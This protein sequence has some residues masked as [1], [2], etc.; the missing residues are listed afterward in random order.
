MQA[1]FTASA[2]NPD[3]SFLTAVA[4]QIVSKCNNL[5]VS[6]IADLIPMLELLGLNKRDDQVRRINTVVKKKLFLCGEASHGLLDVGLALLLHKHMQASTL[7]IWMQKLEE[8]DVQLNYPSPDEIPDPSERGAA[9]EKVT[10]TLRAL[11]EAELHLRYEEPDAM[12]SLQAS[13]KDILERA[14]KTP[15]V[16]KDSHE[17]PEFPFVLEELV[18]HFTKLNVKLIN[19]IHGPYLLDLADPVSKVLVEWNQNWVMLEKWILML[20]DHFYSVLIEFYAFFCLTSICFT[21]EFCW[22]G[23]RH[24]GGLCRR[25]LRSGSIGCCSMKGGRY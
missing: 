19:C 24:I 21:F 5:E 12:L 10:Y 23:I 13:S 9:K 4:K 6:R 3:T 11:K 1:A 25:H 18:S 15:L 22:L 17:I 14:R 7:R 16:I 2:S 8:A 20:F